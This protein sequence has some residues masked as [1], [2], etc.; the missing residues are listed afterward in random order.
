MLSDFMGQNESNQD[1]NKP[2]NSNKGKN[3][4]QKAQNAEEPSLDNKENSMFTGLDVNSSSGA[5]VPNDQNQETK[6]NGTNEKTDAIGDDTAAS[7]SMFAG[8]NIVE[9][10]PSAFSFINESNSTDV[11]PSVSPSSEK[12]TTHEVNTSTTLQSSTG[13][14]PVVEN[15]S[16]TSNEA[17]S[18][19]NKSHLQEPKL[20][21]K[22]RDVKNK[23]TPTKLNNAED[24][25]N[26]HNTTESPTEHKRTSP[27]TGKS[28][29]TNPKSTSKATTTPTK[30][31]KHRPSS[32]I[33][34]EVNSEMVK[35]K[36]R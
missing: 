16:S 32:Q 11:I 13:S 34:N 24:N 8:L 23:S 25:Q 22:K 1:S 9:P 7:S 33:K 35:T 26:N 18:E 10:E 3:T 30:E 36:K 28:E 2:K 20:L 4:P 29:E 15:L 17:I 5:A 31:T 19:A 12:P 14:S 6:T 21:T 27:A